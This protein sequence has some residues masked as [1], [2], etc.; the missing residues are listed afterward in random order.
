[1]ADHPPLQII[2]ITDRIFLNI[3]VFQ[4]VEET[5]LT[6]THSPVPHPG[7]DHTHTHT[8]ARAHADACS[9]Y[10]PRNWFNL[11]NEHVSKSNERNIFAPT[12]RYALSDGQRLMNSL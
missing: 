3:K 4:K 5:D 7:S 2:L 6:A 12:A 8:R 11:I 1:M 10:I 9:S